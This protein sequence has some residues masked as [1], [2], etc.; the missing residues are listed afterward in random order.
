MHSLYLTCCLTGSQWWS[1]NRKVTWSHRDHVIN[2]VL[3]IDK[4]VDAR[5]KIYYLATPQ[6]CFQHLETVRVPGPKSWE[7]TGLWLTLLMA[8]I[9]Y[10]KYL[11]VLI[12]PGGWLLMV[13]TTRKLSYRWQTARCICAIC[14]GV[15]DPLKRPSPYVTA[16]NLVVLRPR[17]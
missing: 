5:H 3:L 16:P 10:A 17:V 6:L 13:S 9:R 4:C 2:T 8:F 11:M 12:D 14:S 7:T 15:A 1:H